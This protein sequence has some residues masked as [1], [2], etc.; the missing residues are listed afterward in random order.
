MSPLCHDML[1]AVTTHRG[2][3]HIHDISQIMHISAGKQVNNSLIVGLSLLYYVLA[4]IMPTN[5]TYTYVLACI[6]DLL[7]F[8]AYI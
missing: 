3:S 8:I 1:L 2:L 6:G 4:K 5:S 7:Y